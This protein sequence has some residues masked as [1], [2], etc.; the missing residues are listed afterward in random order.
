MSRPYD[1]VENLVNQR[2]RDAQVKD[3][4]KV[5]TRHGYWSRVQ[6]LIQENPEIKK[7]M[8]FNMIEK[9]LEE[10]FGLRYYSSFDSFKNSYKKYF[11]KNISKKTK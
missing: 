10:R 5:L 1:Q 11:D 9:E 2:L 8:I 3:E 6:V 4:F 7:E